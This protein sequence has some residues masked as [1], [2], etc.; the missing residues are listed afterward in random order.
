MIRILLV[1]DHDA[2][3]RGVQTMLESHASEEYWNQVQL[4]AL[5]VIIVVLLY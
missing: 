5:E 1:D 3:R 4:S 2:V